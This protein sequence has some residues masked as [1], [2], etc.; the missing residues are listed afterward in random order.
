MRE[1]ESSQSLPLISRLFLSHLLVMIVGVTTSL[2]VA[3][4]F[5]P[6]FF[7]LQL[8]N[9]EGI[10]LDA[11]TARPLLV[12]VFEIAWNRSTFCSVIVGSLAAIALS[13]WVAK[14][15]MQPLTQL[16]EITHKFAAG[17]LEERVPTSE[18][19]ELNELAMSFNRMATSLEGVE[20]RRREIIGDLTHELRT[21]LTVI[22]GYLEKLADRT[23]E[24]SPE[25][26]YRLTKETRRLERLVKD[27]QDLSKA[28]AGYLP[29]NLQPVKLHS[30]LESLV[31]KF[32]DQLLEDGAVLQL[33]CSPDLPPVLGDSDRI[34]QVLVNLLGNAIRYTEKGSITLRAW[35]ESGKGWV[36]L[37]D[38][39][40][41]IAPEDLP[42][43][44]QRFW[45][46]A[47]SR[48]EYSRG[49]GIGLAICRRLIEL[50]GG[51]ISVESELGVGST[52]TFCLP[53]AEAIE[54]SPEIKSR[55]SASMRLD[56]AKF[57]WSSR[58][59]GPK[60]F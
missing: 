2:I 43:V 13:Y 44:F 14:R 15:I 51:D 10:G 55:V 34:E 47:K 38:T 39:G 33:D 48:A 30:M 16:E 18:I 17:Q 56:D 19:P 4:V 52:F 59:F 60:I 31:E 40:H 1:F 49:T 45:R 25:I 5:Y 24:P 58:F 23:I 29:V 37:T 57:R 12:E 9:L 41:G 11:V 27:L 8:G 54:R 53:L 46:S 50:Q 21:P 3:K 6:H 35:S 22:R 42:H 20:Q 36:A 7:L 32:S 28:E 26:Y